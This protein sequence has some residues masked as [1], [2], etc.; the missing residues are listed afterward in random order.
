MTTEFNLDAID[1]V[2]ASAGEELYVEIEVNL[3]D[4]AADE[5]RRLRSIIDGYEGITSKPPNGR[6]GQ[7]T[8]ELATDLAWHVGRMR[9]RAERAEKALHEIEAD[10]NR[11]YKA[12]TSPD[13]GDSTND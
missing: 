12:I 11:L 13:L 8:G 10:W 1:Q 3:L 7:L 4:S 9:A 2:V 6:A 5:I